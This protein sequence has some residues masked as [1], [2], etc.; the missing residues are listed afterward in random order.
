MIQI[1]RKMFEAN[2]KK[3]T[4][5]LTDKCSGCGCEAIIYIT[6]TS[7]GFGL[8]GGTLLKR[9]PDGYSIKCPDCRQANSKIDDHQK[10]EKKFIR[11]LLVE[12]ELTSRRIL[13]SFLYPF[14]KVDVAV[15]GKE[16]FKAV[17]KSIENSQPYELIFLDIM[18]H[19]LDG[20][21]TL[22]KIR[23]LETQHEMNGGIK[24]KIIVTSANTDRDVILK[25]AHADCNAYMIKPIDKTRLYNEIRKQ[26]FDIPEPN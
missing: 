4:I 14:G 16:A 2:P 13:N 20:I 19:E 12:D 6:P 9:S 21:A 1:L 8:Q 7:G 26:G 11:I 22:K 3:S 10:N 25:A 23:Q 24:S 15:N 5:V 18:M 17:K